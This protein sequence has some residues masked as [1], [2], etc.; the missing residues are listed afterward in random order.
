MKKL[1]LFAAAAA[2]L[3]TPHLGQAAQTTSEMK[4]RIN[5]TTDARVER[6]MHYKFQDRGETILIEGKKIYTLTRNGQKTFAPNGPYTSP[7]G[8]TFVA[9]DGVVMH[10]NA[11]YKIVRID[12]DLKGQNYDNSPEYI[13]VDTHTRKYPKRKYHR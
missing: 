1:T 6:P 5:T 9:H 4:M 3:L 12:S 13:G 2:L 11:P 10:T 7:E 8:L